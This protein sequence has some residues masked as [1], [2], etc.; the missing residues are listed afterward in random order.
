MKA[1]GKKDK[2]KFTTIDGIGITTDTFHP[3]AGLP[4]F[5]RYLCGINLF[6]ELEPTFR[7]YEKECQRM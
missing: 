6:I 4:L 2:K 7:L 5:V 3:E 1:S